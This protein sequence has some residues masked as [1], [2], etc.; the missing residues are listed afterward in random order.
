MKTARAVVVDALM[1]QDQ[2][3]YA[4]LVLDGA[5]KKA[6]LSQQDAAFASAIFYGTIERRNTLDH[7]L[8][9]YLKKGGV[10][11]LDPAVRAILRSGLYQ[12]RYMQSVPNAA[13]VNEAVK[14]TREFH[15]GS[16]SGLVN[17]VLRRA[18][19]VELSDISFQ[20]E[21]QRLS[22]VQSVSVPIAELLLRYYGSEAEQIL[23]ESF[24]PARTTIRVNYLKNSEE[25]LCAYLQEQKIPAE[26]GS[27]PGC[28]HIQYKG[29]PAQHPG[30]LQG[31]FYVQGEPSQI[32]ACALEV[33]PGQKVL[34]LC[35]APGGKS[36]ALAGLMQNQGELYSCDA[37]PS[38]VPLIE[39]AMKRC[40][41]TIARVMQADA[42]RYNKN[43]AEA[44]RVLCDVP[45][46]GLGILGKKPDIRYKELEE[47]QKLCA[48][49]QKILQNASRY[50][51]KGGILVYST[52]TIDPE[53]NT[54]VVAEFLQKN[55]DFISLPV[56]NAPSGAL[57]D[58]VQGITILPNRC[59]MDGF[60]VARVQKKQ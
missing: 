5:L 7:C 4:N 17:A 29:N 33:Q 13:A 47:L 53:E 28:Y 22:V 10:R 40:G 21:A 12:V 52:C 49:Q 26:A 41:V 42:S 39:R 57:V 58:E 43:F 37:S 30:F 27:I 55:P 18:A 16:A 36:L 9:C 8:G 59:G 51:K 45:C 44:D 20:N 23:A 25:E 46:S 1:H 15:K 50:V 6:N 56:P 54:R 19:D 35:A 38:R 31:R 34:D 32:A 48:L 14:L 60:Y 3:G 24:A 11:K 2:E